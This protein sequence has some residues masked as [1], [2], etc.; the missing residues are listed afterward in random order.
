MGLFLSR[1]TT[2]WHQPMRCLIRYGQYHTSPEHSRQE[3]CLHFVR[4]ASD[5][6]LRS[7]AKECER[8][9]PTGGRVVER[10]VAR[11]YRCKSPMRTSGGMFKETCGKGFDK[12]RYATSLYL[13]PDKLG[14]Q[15][16]RL[17]SLILSVVS[18]AFPMFLCHCRS[19]L[20]VGVQ[21]VQNQGLDHPLWIG[22]VLGAVLFKCVKDLCVEA[23]SS[24]DRLR[25][26]FR[27]GSRFA[28]SHNG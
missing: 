15:F 22:K 11:R 1:L 19:C 21:P 8:W 23:V 16:I 17:L 4:V 25:V 14:A 26:L 18:N 9:Q 28:F 6:Q 10:D 7:H 13:T 20:R 27:F 3:K 12:S 2:E 5:S 24:L